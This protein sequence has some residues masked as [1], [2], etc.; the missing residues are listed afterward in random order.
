MQWAGS[1]HDTS[2]VR[3]DDEFFGFSFASREIWLAVRFMGAECVAAATLRAVARRARWH[4]LARAHGYQ[5]IRASF[6]AARSCRPAFRCT[7]SAMRSSGSFLDAAAY[8]VS[9][10]TTE[11]GS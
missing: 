3:R 1:S 5:L 10:T 7:L 8:V 2:S 6:F 11:F 9:R 4:A